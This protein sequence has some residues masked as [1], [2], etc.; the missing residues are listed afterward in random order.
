MRDKKL[1]KKVRKLLAEKP[2]KHKQATWMTV[3][4][5]SVREKL[6][7][8]TGE[9]KGGISVSCATNACVAGHACLLSGDKA[10]I[11][12]RTTAFHGAFDVEYVIDKDGEQHFIQDR[13]QDLMGLTSQEAQHLFKQGR[14]RTALIKDL[15]TLIAGGEIV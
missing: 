12:A 14:H 1:L 5:S 4:A 10:W 11:N 2:D 15:D 6:A 3:T 13:A 9:G 8:A 7:R